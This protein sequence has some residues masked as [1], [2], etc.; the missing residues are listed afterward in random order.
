MARFRSNEYSTVYFKPV[1][2][3][4]HFPRNKQKK[5]KSPLKDRNLRGAALANYAYEIANVLRESVVSIAKKYLLV[6]QIFIGRKYRKLRCRCK[7]KKKPRKILFLLCCVKKKLFYN[8]KSVVSSS[9]RLFKLSKV[10]HFT[11]NY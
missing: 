6:E 8:T 11:R 2:L 7:K 5:K 4:E 1:N 3:N 9:S 10:F